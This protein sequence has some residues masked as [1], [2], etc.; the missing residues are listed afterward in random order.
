MSQQCEGTTAMMVMCRRSNKLSDPRK[1][2]DLEPHKRHPTSTASLHL[3]P[4]VLHPSTPPPWEPPRFS[5]AH[6]PSRV[7][8][9][10]VSI[11]E[12]PQ[13]L[14]QGGMPKTF[15]TCFWDR[16]QAS[17][18]LSKYHQ[19]E[20]RPRGQQHV[21]KLKQNKLRVS[22]HVGCQDSQQSDTRV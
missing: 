2:L 20:P 3:A 11:L 21:P 5:S 9:T 4:M 14:G 17:L 10:P 18:S 19:E 15:C 12:R 13:G 22:D 8:V 7:W 16:E 1:S 6:E